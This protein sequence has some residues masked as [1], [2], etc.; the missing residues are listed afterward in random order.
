[1]GYAQDHNHRQH[2]FNLLVII[3]GVVATVVI[4]FL[5][6]GRSFTSA[7]KVTRALMCDFVLTT[8]RCE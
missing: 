1:M 7:W 4:L 6:L 8:V 5:Q 2:A 3:G